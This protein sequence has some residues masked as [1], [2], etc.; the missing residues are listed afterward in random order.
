MRGLY[1]M[2][3]QES[4]HG[5]NRGRRVDILLA[6]VVENLHV[7][8]PVMPLVGFVQVESDLYGH[9]IWHSTR[10]PP[11]SAARKSALMF[12]IPAAVCR[13][14]PNRRTDPICGCVRA[15]SLRDAYPVSPECVLRRHW[16]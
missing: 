12:A 3:S 10:E 1:A 7:Q 4:R 8:R 13:T 14:T 2:A 5:V 16:V 6:Q 11:R 9:R 15:G